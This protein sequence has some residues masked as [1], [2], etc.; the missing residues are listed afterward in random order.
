MRWA[1][2]HQT[3]EATAEA[4]RQHRDKMIWC[5]NLIEQGYMAVEAI[6]DLGT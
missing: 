2:Q 4:V 6:M 1:R 3:P 5:E